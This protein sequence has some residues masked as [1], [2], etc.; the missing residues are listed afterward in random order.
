MDENL[1][2]LLPYPQMRIIENTLYEYAK[3]TPY[4][5][6]EETRTRQYA[7]EH[8]QAFVQQTIPLLRPLDLSRA[9]AEFHSSTRQKYTLQEISFEYSCARTPHASL[10]KYHPC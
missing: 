5:Q 1:T 2:V 4:L 9:R 7:C 10:L 6:M 8:H 3:H